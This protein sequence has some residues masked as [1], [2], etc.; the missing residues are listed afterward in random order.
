MHVDHGLR[1]GSAAEAERVADAAARYGARFRRERGHRRCPGPNLEARAR[2]ARY[3]RAARR[4]AHGPHRRRPGRDGAAATCCGA[5]AG[6]AWP[7]CAGTSADPLLDL[8]RAETAALCVGRGP[9]RRATTRPTDDPDPPPQPGAPRGAAA[10]R[11]RRR[12]RRRAG[13]G[14]PGR[15]WRPSEADLLDA[16]GRRP[17][18]HRRPASRSAEP[19]AGPP[20]RCGR[21]CGGARAPSCHRR[22]RHRRPGAGRGRRRGAAAPTWPAGWRVR[23][24]RRPPPPGALSRVGDRAGAAGVRSAATMGDR[25]RATTD[26]CS[27]PTTRASAG[28]L[29]TED[30]AGD[31]AHRRAGR[32]DHPGL[33][34]AGAPLLVGV[35]K[36]AFV[37]MTDL[38]RRIDLPVEIDFIAVSSYGAATRTSGV[39]RIVKDLDIDLDRPRRDPGRGH[40]RQRPD[41][42]LPAPQPRG[43][44]PG[45]PRGVRPAARE[46]ADLEGRRALRR[47]SPSP[48]TSS[49]GYGLDV[50]ERYRNLRYLAVYQPPED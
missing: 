15:T 43:P 20:G 16:P 50:A 7:A 31:P 34:R 35:L 2:A 19:A 4:R 41:P 27:A 14:P 39:V 8:R 13:A 42:A 3:A 12:P 26:Q 18:P 1:P 33:R 22:R 45:Q 29:V 21:G 25:R 38:A 11:R 5:R 48:A 28:S 44:R 6:R 49:I 32:A 47:A 10:A 36:G 46:S 24:G 30:A 37:F 23:R 17:R 9:R 40:R